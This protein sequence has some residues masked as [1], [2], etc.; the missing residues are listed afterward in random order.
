MLTSLLSVSLLRAGVTSANRSTAASYGGAFTFGPIFAL[1]LILYARTRSNRAPTLRAHM[2]HH[3]CVVA[4]LSHMLWSRA[5]VCAGIDA[6]QGSGA[7][8]HL[9]GAREQARSKRAGAAE[10]CGAGGS[11]AAASRVRIQTRDGANTRANTVS[12][13]CISVLIHVLLPVLA[14]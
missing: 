1:P 2:A 3:A 11:C 13:R 8:A 5:T 14:S 9:H 12:S 4:R 6:G 7:R 10:A